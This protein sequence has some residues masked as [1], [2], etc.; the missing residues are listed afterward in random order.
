M[1]VNRCW[2]CP[3]RDCRDVVLSIF[4]ASLQ[5]SVTSVTF[6]ES[7]RQPPK[8]CPLM[9]LEYLAYQPSYRAGNGAISDQQGAKA[10]LP[11]YD[12]L[13]QLHQKLGYLWTKSPETL[14]NCSP[15]TTP[16][17]VASICIDLG[18]N[19]AAKPVAD[20]HEVAFGHDVHDRGLQHSNVVT[21]SPCLPRCNQMG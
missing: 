9:N 14:Y 18:L 19:T 11:V 6:S 16:F 4:S 13:A 20:P 5:L 10:K 12:H 2:H 21:S 7:K 3:L 15:E 8:S 17:D 1:S